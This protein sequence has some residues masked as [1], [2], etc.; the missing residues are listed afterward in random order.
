MNDHYME[1]YDIIREDERQADNERE[2]TER[3]LRHDEHEPTTFERANPMLKTLMGDDYNKYFNDEQYHDHY[4]D[5]Q[6]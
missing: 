3:E 5:N 6:M 4:Q 2:Y 1:A